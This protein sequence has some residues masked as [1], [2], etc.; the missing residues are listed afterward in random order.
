MT[1]DVGCA[2]STFF[3]VRSL[4]RFNFGVRIFLAYVVRQ[5][6]H[7]VHVNQKQL[8]LNPASTSEKQLQKSANQQ[9]YYRK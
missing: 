4:N 1:C 3:S 5:Y 8:L 2:K 7:V 6:S 9:S